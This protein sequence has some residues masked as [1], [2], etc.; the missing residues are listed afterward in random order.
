MRLVQPGTISVFA[1]LVVLAGAPGWG[2]AAIARKSAVAVQTSPIFV[3]GR[4]HNTRARLTFI[5][6]RPLDMTIRQVPEGIE[7]RTEGDAAYQLAK[8]PQ[9]REVAGI[10][11]RTEGGASIA[12]IRLTCECKME[13]EHAGNKVTLYLAETGSRRKLAAPAP[14][15]AVKTE[16]DGLMDAL[17]ERLALLNTH[18]YGS[19]ARPAPGP[20][21]VPVPQSAP[22]STLRAAAQARVSDMSVPA[23]EPSPTPALI[24][25]PSCP[26]DFSMDGWKGDGSFPKNLQV[27]RALVAKSEESPP[28]M[29][30]LAEF[31]LGN[32]LGAEA[33]AIAQEVK[34]D[35]ISTEDRR[36]LLRDA[37]LARLL[38]AQPIESTS[39]LLNSPADCERTDIPLWRVLSAVASG[40]QEI[41]RRDG[42]AAGQI[43]QSLPEPV[44][45]L[46][47]Y[48]ITEAD[49]DDLPVLRAMAGAIR[50]SGNG[51]VAD[52]AGRFFLQSRMARARKD[53]VEEASFIE[54]VTHD[55]G[56]MGLKARER[57]AELRSTQDDDEGR[58]SESI[59]A[60]T[61][62]VYR[63]IPLGQ[64]AAAALSEQR[65]RHGDYAGA[66]R[67]ANDITAGN[68]L[69]QADSRGATLAARALRQLLVDRDAPDLP[70]PEQ[71]L[72]IYWRYSGY[73][74]PG[75]KGDD[76]RLGAAQ[77]M[78]DQG[79]P[80]AA[81]DVMR[82][83]SDSSV[84]SPRGALLR[85]IA[86]A[87]AG[88]ANAALALLK[89]IPRNDDTQRAG[90]D[91]LV[92]LGKLVEGAHQLDDVN[93]ASDQ[94]RRAALLYEAKEW[95]DAAD[96][97]A[98]VLRRPSLGKDARAEAADR[99]ALALAL[100]GKQPV[101]G[102]GRFT[103]LAKHVLGALSGQAD[104]Q[105]RPVAALRGA[106]RRAV[107]IEALLPPSGHAT[108][109]NGG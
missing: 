74:T 47:A 1:F 51:D 106:L 70:S 20:A 57:L 67:V 72:L 22:I 55:I 104:P 36:R 108:P 31:Y 45:N 63:D 26:P 13:Q 81:L 8:L 82:Q 18:G 12:L 88:D 62:R 92:R 90:A 76:I 75:E 9:L 98:G 107:Q 39:V 32:G 37:D 89:T 48:R 65:L 41:I 46:L 93:G 16:M 87:R 53:P 95:S 44:S 5:M 56:V 103:G 15:A 66:L 38:T 94:A 7:V 100:S 96:A 68:A 91:A 101:E 80:E 99:Y 24:R 25:R 29:A 64:S 78:L 42:E 105:P 33:L 54:H 61:A 14:E 49:G 2:N 11:L 73:A 23:G 19:T 30:A 97:Y 102:L 40:D 4:Q 6:D 86:E 52:A 35:G 58:K 43:L 71:R 79:M 3:L 60:D 27:L 17:A 85:A 10:D 83:L 34:L 28:A 84:R 21:T 59:L 77:L 109:A 69:Q 50:N